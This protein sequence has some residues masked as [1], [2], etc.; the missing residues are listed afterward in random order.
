[1]ELDDNRVNDVNND[2]EGD[3]DVENDHVQLQ[4]FPNIEIKEWEQYFFTEK[5]LHSIV[6]SLQYEENIVCLCTPAVADA[7]MR[8]KNK[9]VVC[10]DID[11][12]FNYLPG[13]IKYDLLNPTK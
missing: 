6:D 11:E 4:D 13:F 9:K 10:L 3:G 7:F 2:N 8:F 1:M 12:R 5:V